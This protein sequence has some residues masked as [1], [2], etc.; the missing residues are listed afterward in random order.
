MLYIGNFLTFYYKI[1][2]KEINLYKLILEA[3]S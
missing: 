2:Q 3:T 1:L